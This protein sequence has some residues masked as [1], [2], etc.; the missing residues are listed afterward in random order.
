VFYDVGEIPGVVGVAI[1]HCA[2]VIRDG[3]GTQAR[4]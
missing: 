1:I 4:R 3:V 2:G